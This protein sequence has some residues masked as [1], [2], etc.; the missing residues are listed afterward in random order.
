MWHLLLSA[1]PRPSSCRRPPTAAGHTPPIPI[2][3]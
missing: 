3:S 2:I 1:S